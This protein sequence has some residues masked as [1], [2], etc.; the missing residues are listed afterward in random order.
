[1]D[2]T[3]EKIIS[4]ACAQTDDMVVMALNPELNEHVLCN[5]F[6]GFNARDER[7]FALPTLRGTTSASLALAA[8]RRA[9]RLQAA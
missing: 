1:M 8:W 2:V 5:I 6:A 7:V 4:T 9:A 3:N